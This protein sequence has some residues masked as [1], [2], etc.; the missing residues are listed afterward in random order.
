MKV[1]RL[2]PLA[3]LAAL[4]LAPACA[5]VPDASERP[6]WDAGAPD[7]APDAA[8]VAYQ[9]PCR[10][11]GTG[12]SRG[13]M[14][15]L[16]RAAPTGDGV[17][18]RMLFR[19]GTPDSPEIGR[20]E[21]LTVGVPAEL[22][23]VVS[24]LGAGANGDLSTCVNCM[25]AYRQ[26]AND[27]YQCALGPYFPR[28]GQA[29]TQQVAA[30]SGAANAV[31]LSAMEMVRVEVAADGSVQALSGDE[32]CLYYDYLRL[33]NTAA[34]APADCDEGFHCRLAESASD[35]HPD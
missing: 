28:S 1:S 26:C 2:A 14:P 22:R 20:M 16:L 10:S 29:V 5:E 19:F 18:V 9:G 11:Y 32:D 27:G 24:E 13:E 23:G 17:A 31:E 25:F 35:H 12:I 33:S 7:A 8:P 15:T 4:G 3:L 30:A 21:I 6:A 34:T